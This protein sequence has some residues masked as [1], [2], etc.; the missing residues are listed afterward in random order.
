MIKQDLQQKYM[1]FQMLSRQVNILSQQTQ[2]INNKIIEL[3][4]LS[5]SI[6]EISNINKDTEILV[7][8]GAG[9]L[10]KASIKDSKSLLMNVGADVVL[11]KTHEEAH[12]IIESQVSELELALSQTE[13]ELAEI[14]STLMSIQEELSNSN[15]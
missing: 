9:I 15:E 6:N 12:A 8:L 13:S 3:K 1:E 14:N 2:L 11:N 7:P 4:T 5:Q 10:M